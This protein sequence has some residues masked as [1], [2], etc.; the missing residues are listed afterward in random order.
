MDTK[1]PMSTP[2]EE[3]APP[4]Y[5]ESASTTDYQPQN[6]PIPAASQPHSST[7]QYYSHQI[8]DQ[9]QSLTSQIK[10]VETQ[11]SLLSHAQDEKILSLLTT[12]IQIYLSDWAKSGLH[13]GTLILVPSVA[14]PDEKALPVD[15][16]FKDPDTYDRVV[17]V[18]DKEAEDHGEGMWF[19]NDEEKALRLARY[20]RPKKDLKNAELPPRKPESE[21]GRGWGWKRG[22]SRA[23]ERP[24]LIGDA[25]MART[26][27]GHEVLM[28]VKAEEVV[29]RTENEFGIYE[30]QRGYGMVLKLRVVFG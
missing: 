16:D 22:N 8:Q 10:S 7:S 5:T 14:I 28:T 23:A 15:F 24:P 11:K 20:L 13:R 12:Q 30:T 21:K 27:T 1:F 4:A 25:K 2:Q 3:A 18:R 26:K 29:F 19:W 17:R 9:L 6:E